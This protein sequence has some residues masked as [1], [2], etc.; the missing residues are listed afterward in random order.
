MR[1]TT[2]FIFRFLLNEGQFQSVSTIRL[3]ALQCLT[4]N[5]D[6]EQGVGTGQAPFGFQPVKFKHRHNKRNMFNLTVSILT[7][8]VLC[9][10]KP[11]LYKAYL[12]LNLRTALTLSGSGPDVLALTVSPNW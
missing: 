4:L 9:T 10:G 7:E 8:D 6:R 2:N 5:Y 11:T 3:L 12:L 1:T